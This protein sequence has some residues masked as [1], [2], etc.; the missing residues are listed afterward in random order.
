MDS[1][2]RNVGILA[3]G[4]VVL[5]LGIGGIGAANAAAPSAPQVSTPHSAVHVAKAKDAETKDAKADTETK[6]GNAESSE[7]AA[8]DGPNQGPDVNPS[9]PGHQDAGSVNDQSNG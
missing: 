2:K 5:A 1:K 4:A 8:S 3:G 6:D 9:E 7:T